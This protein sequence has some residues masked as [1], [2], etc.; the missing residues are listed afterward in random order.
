M[1]TINTFYIN[2]HREL[3]NKISKWN[4]TN[5]W[6]PDEFQKS[7]VKPLQNDYITMEDYRMVVFCFIFYIIN[8]NF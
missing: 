8:I 5:Q 1:T 7:K 2:N 6:Y 3:I 4:L